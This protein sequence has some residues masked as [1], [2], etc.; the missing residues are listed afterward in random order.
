MPK[1]PSHA[2]SNW[3]IWVILVALLCFVL[4][5]GLGLF[6]HHAIQAEHDKCVACQVAEH[7]ALDVPN[8]SFA[9]LIVLLFLVLPWRPRA[10]P[11]VIVFTRPHSRAPPSNFVS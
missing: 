3:R 4:F 1:H 2:K 9:P 7:Q 11:S 10:V 8:V 6:H 5:H